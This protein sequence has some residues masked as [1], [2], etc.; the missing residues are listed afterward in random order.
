MIYQEIDS[1]LTIQ[2]NFPFFCTLLLA[3]DLVEWHKNISDLTV[4]VHKQMLNCEIR[5]SCSQIARDELEWVFASS[6]KR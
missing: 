3:L 2:Q 4:Q 1:W 5:K 6:G